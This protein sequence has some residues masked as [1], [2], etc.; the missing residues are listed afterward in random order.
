MTTD[1]LRAKFNDISAILED[2]LLQGMDAELK[3]KAYNQMK[4][5]MIADKTKLQRKEEEL[6]KIEQKTSEEKFYVLKLSGELD[7]KREELEKRE[8]EAQIIIKQ[9]ENNLKILSDKEKIIDE[10]RKAL[11]VD[12]EKIRDM[13]LKEKLLDR[14][15]AMI[16][17]RKKTLDFKEKELNLKAERL[18]RMM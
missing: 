4:Q 7:K 14:E 11:V 15:K 9:G 12:E 5:E 13:A 10:K 17:E 16:E 18:Q 3:M 1:D 2:L 6:K 8:K